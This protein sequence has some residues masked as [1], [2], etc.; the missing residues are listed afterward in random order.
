MFLDTPDGPPLSEAALA[1]MQ[2]SASQSRSQMSSA[3]TAVTAKTYK[4]AKTACTIN[5]HSAGD[6][7]GYVAYGRAQINKLRD[8]LRAKPYQKIKVQP[9]VSA[10]EKAE[11][12]RDRLFPSLGGI[13]SRVSVSPSTPVPESPLPASDF[14]EVDVQDEVHR[15]S[16]VL[17]ERCLH[18]GRF[19]IFKKYLSSTM[20][21]HQSLEDQQV[22]ELNLYYKDLKGLRNVV[23]IEAHFHDPLGNLTFVFPDLGVNIYPREKPGIVSYMRQLLNGLDALWQKEIVHCNIKGGSKPNAIFD[24]TG[25][26]TIID[27]ESAV[28]RHELIDQGQDQESL[29]FPSSFHTETLL[30]RGNPHYV[31]PEVFV[32]QHGRSPYGKTRFGRRRDIYSAGVVFVELLLDITKLFDYGIRSASNQL[33]VEQHETLRNRLA[34]KEPLS[35]LHR[36]GDFRVPD[37]EFNTLGSDLACRM[38]KWDRCERPSPQKLL[39][40]PFFHSFNA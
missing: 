10:Q 40:H 17:V 12:V 34:S 24:A 31:A 8:Q 19:M 29:F 11:N 28:R 4:T 26:L 20:P 18:R 1:A 30:Y 5:V 22:Y 3:A 36:Y 2:G 33:I 7:A 37:L 25:R 13:L 16:D 32:A 15:E 38:L 21:T 39:Q 23:Q 27:F 9:H 35:A 6:T 14:E